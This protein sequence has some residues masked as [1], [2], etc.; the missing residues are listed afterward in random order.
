MKGV[1]TAKLQ[2]MCNRFSFHKATS[3]TFIGVPFGQMPKR[4]P[5]HKSPSGSR[6]WY[7]E[8]GVYRLSDHWGRV[9]SCHWYLVKDNYLI[10]KYTFKESFD[11]IYLTPVIA[12]SSWEAFITD[13]YG[14][15][16]RIDRSYK[17]NQ[18]RLKPQN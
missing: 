4:L 6:Y 14:L 13:Q 12:F 2:I 18:D 1:L 15:S 5:D 3:C 7:E 10:G 17:I 9:S 16:E 11:N 8:S